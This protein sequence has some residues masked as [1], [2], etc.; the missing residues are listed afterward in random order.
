LVD[1][2][3]S[4][5]KVDPNLISVPCFR[6]PETMYFIY[7]QPAVIAVLKNSQKTRVD[8]QPTLFNL[9]NFN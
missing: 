4:V 2:L 3:L 1:F 9:P 5:F 6:K 7:L 8:N